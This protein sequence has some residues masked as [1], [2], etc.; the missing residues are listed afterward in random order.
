MSTLSEHDL[1]LIWDEMTDLAKLADQK[2]RSLAKEVA[3]DYDYV[4]GV[5]EEM[6]DADFRAPK[7]YIT[8]KSRNEPYMG[9][10]WKKTDYD[11]PI[12]KYFDNKTY[13]EWVAEQLSKFNPVGFEVVEVLEDEEG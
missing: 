1:C 7:Y 9:P 3:A 5:F 8:K 4:R 12:S 11:Y 6:L 2:M 13:A 10:T